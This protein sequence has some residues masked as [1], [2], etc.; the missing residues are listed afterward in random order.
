MPLGKIKLLFNR[1]SGGHKGVESVRKATKTDAFIRIKMGVSPVGAKGKAKRPDTDKI[2]DFIVGKFK[3]PEL[4][5]IKKAA[6]KVVE[7]IS[8]IILESKEKAMSEFNQG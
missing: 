7:A 8:V 4:D 5:L 3:K 6:K 1:G 2:M